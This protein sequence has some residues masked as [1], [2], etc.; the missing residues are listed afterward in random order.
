MLRRTHTGIVFD[1]ICISYF[2]S[3]LTLHCQSGNVTVPGR[4]RKGMQVQIP[5]LPLVEYRSCIL[6]Y[7]FPYRIFT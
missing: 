3:Y 1:R 2:V 7:F 4:S 6:S 5:Y